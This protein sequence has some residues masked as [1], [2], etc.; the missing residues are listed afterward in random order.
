MGCNALHSTIHKNY[1]MQHASCM[2]ATTTYKT[3]GT[4]KLQ[5]NNNELKIIIYSYVQSKSPSTRYYQS[6]PRGAENYYS[7]VP[8][9]KDVPSLLVCRGK[10]CNWCNK[11]LKLKKREHLWKSSTWNQ[12]TKLFLW[13]CYYR[14]GQN[15]G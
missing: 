6:T 15:T 10:F 11:Y 7:K 5:I 12:T 3:T 14:S 1:A 4:T 8:N 2:T 13:T 9:I